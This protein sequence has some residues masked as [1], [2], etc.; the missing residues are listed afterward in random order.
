[1]TIKKGKKR[2]KKKKKERSNEKNDPIV[3][4]SNVNLTLSRANLSGVGGWVVRVK[5]PSNQR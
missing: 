3:S 1:M 5:T 2:K 4:G